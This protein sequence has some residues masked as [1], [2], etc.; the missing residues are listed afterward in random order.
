MAERLGE[1]LLELG[2][3][4][5]GFGKGIDRAEGRA[6]QLGRRFEEVG[7]RA[8]RLGRNLSIGVTAPMAA[9]G[10]TSLRAFMQQ[11]RSIAR[12][13][14]A[15]AATGGAVGLTSGQLQIMA[16]E[17]QKVSTFGDEDILE[18][19][20]A[21]LLRFTSITGTEFVRAQELAV[22]M[23]A[24]TGASLEQVARQIGL[25]LESPADGLTLLR[26]SGV[27]F[28][29]E[30]EAAVKQL[31][32]AGKTAEAQGVLFEGLA[33]RFGGAAQAM[34]RTTEGELTQIN[35]AW[36][37]FQE[38]LGAVIAEVLPPLTE[39][40][41][42]LVAWL[43]DLDPQT[44]A[45][46][47]AIGAV[48]AAL[49]PAIA[50]LGLMVA[51]IGA[52]LP[53]IAT[54]G[55]AIMGLV[56]ASGPLGLLAL[57]VTGL[58]VYFQNFEAISGIFQRLYEAARDWLMDKLGGVLDFVGDKVEAVKGFFGDL[59]DSVVGNSF[60]PDL[61]DGIE[62]E[63]ARLDAVMVKPAEEAAGHVADA[64]S[65]IADEVGGLLD[66]LLTD[67]KLGLDDLRSA[68]VSVIG[69]LRSMAFD[70]LKTSLSGA[71]GNLVPGFAHGGSFTVG[72]VGG[73]D[74]NLVAF[75]A[76]RGERVDITPAGQ[77]GRGGAINVTMNIAT[78]DVEG[79]RRA[80]GQ[81]LAD[82][83]RGIDR[84]QRNR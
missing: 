57:A 84:G 37:D 12:V 68:A 62:R 65:A 36:G 31:A 21:G 32:E 16:S 14:A 81:V 23:A 66:K 10:A 79:F 3:D 63:F 40:L 6:R 82:L 39:L 74:R 73:V 35:N 42:D 38:Q 61:V 15:L 25:A 7:K 27:V 69:S 49:G 76:T 33:E 19:L 46:A 34:A 48:A 11:E 60:I 55:T 83:S 77:S 64:F 5:K 75:R 51:G 70:S 44:V 1:A 54:L 17:L 4:D 43:Q 71:F 28:G 53:V 18:N 78:P 58:V 8:Q 50:G 26:R 9:L 41:R 30:T 52:M 45:W 24:Q 13:E 59:Y 29:K 22:D 80:R 2:T 20:T 72:G 67:G 56:A 47:V